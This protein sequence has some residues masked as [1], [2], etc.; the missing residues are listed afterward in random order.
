MKKIKI[1]MVV[2]NLTING[3]SN[4]IKNYSE[5]I[6][7]DKFEITIIAGMPIANLYQKLYHNLKIELI[8]LPNYQKNKFRYYINLFKNLKNKKFDIIHIHGNSINCLVELLLA[9]FVNIKSRIMHIHNSINSHPF[10]HK[11]LFPIFILICTD[12]F[13]CGKLAGDWFYGKKKY[14]IIPN[15]F[16]T[17]KFQFN[18]YNRNN[19]RK[20]LGLSNKVVIGHVGRFNY[21]KNQEFL[22]NIFTEVASKNKNY[23]LL[24]VGN[25]PDY[26]KIKD[27][28]SNSPFK[29]R[30]ILYGETE[31]T[32]I[33]YSAID[34]FILPSRY[35]GLPIVLLEAQISGLPCIVSDVVTKEVNLGNIM[36]QS[37][38]TN[39]SDWSDLVL[40][41]KPNIQKREKFYEEN[42]KLINKYQI[43][44]NVKE[45]E[46][47]YFN[48]YTRDYKKIEC[49]VQ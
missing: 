14:K 43:K 13:A 1:A 8:A 36:W 31:N 35:E 6:N 10:L 47:I 41:I 15:G 38:H 27:L 42:I 9:Y 48:I 40:N 21:Q 4:V 12:Y 5:N 25:G 26:I 18:N 28:I 33:L 24:L 3:I 29:D 30:I 20:K 49:D 39:Y 22:L 34:I 7:K 2:H 44:E 17:E 16:E 46:K 23:Y 37:L 45:L 11:L 19:L 32:S